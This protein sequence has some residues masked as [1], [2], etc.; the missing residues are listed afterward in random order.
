[1]CVCVCVCVCVCGMSLQMNINSFPCT[2]ISP[3]VFPNLPPGRHVFK[4][5]PFGCGRNRSPVNF[6]ADIDAPVIEICRVV[7]TQPLVVTG[8]SVTIH[9]QGLGPSESFTCFLDRQGRV[10]RN[11]EWYNNNIYII[12]FVQL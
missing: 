8:N 3:V 12:V 9:F 4:I 2:G 5:T 7:L 11:C 10:F 6:F 1:M